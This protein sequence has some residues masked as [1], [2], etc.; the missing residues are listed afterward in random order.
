MAQGEGG[1]HFFFHGQP[2]AA[3]RF[4]D[5]QAKQAQLAHFFDDVVGNAVECFD[6]AFCRNQ[7]LAHKALQRGEQNVKVS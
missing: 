4:R 5:R 6:S 2:H 3:M 1:Q 7:P